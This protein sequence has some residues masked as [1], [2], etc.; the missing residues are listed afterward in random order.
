MAPVVF[1]LIKLPF[2]SIL[3][4]SKVTKTGAEIAEYLV[5]GKLW[6]EVAYPA[7]HNAAKKFALQ[8]YKHDV[9]TGQRI[10]GFI[11]RATVNEYGIPLRTA[12]RTTPKKAGPLLF[13]LCVK[14]ETGGTARELVEY[15]R[16]LKA[17]WHM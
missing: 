2:G 11:D 7:S 8:G 1:N 15:A 12:W 17:H 6:K 16:E 9:A 4:N 14:S 5:N 10:Y 13:R 3:K